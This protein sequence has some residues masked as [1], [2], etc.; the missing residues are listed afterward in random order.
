MNTTSE[1]LLLRLRHTEDDA[2]WS[3]FV[4][5]Y[6]PMLFQWARRTGLQPQDA[7]DLVQEVL[8][9]LFRKLP[10]FNYDSNKSFRSWLKT[11]TI[12][13]YREFCRRKSVSRNAVTGTV[14]NDLLAEPQVGSK[15]DVSYQRS[16][17]QTALEIIRPEFRPR[18]WDAVTKFLMEQQTAAQISQETGVSPWTIY[19]AKSRLMAR[20]REELNGLIE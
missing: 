15:W 14:I 19:A 4:E 8:T 2:A 20:L 13:K 10:D 12:N 1:S 11:I 7:S 16:I 3:R 5:L 9:I 18:T 17:F 6:T